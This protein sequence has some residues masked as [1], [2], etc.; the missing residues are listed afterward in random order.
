MEESTHVLNN[1]LHVTLI[2]N[3]SDP[4][5]KVG[6]WVRSG[7][8]MDS[9]KW[10]GSLTA[11][12]IMRGTKMHSR[13]KFE[14][15]LEEHSLLYGI[16]PSGVSSFFTEWVGGTPS[17]EHL[18]D[19][20]GL[21][22]E[23]LQFPSF[24][25]DE[26]EIVRAQKEAAIVKN[27]NDP[28]SNAKSE[29]R[30]MLYG[31]T[32]PLFALSVAENT[33]NLKAVTRDNLESFWKKHY[34][35]GHSGIVVVGDIDPLSVCECIDEVFGGWVQ[36][37]SH[38]EPNWD[39][40]DFGSDEYEERVISLPGNASA[41]LLI[42]QRMP[43]S[44]THSDYPAL[45]IAIN[46]LGGGMHSRLFQHVREKHGLSYH[47]GA[48]LNGMHTMPGY[49]SAI[50]MTNPDNI[51]KTQ[52][53]T[54]RVITEFCDKGITEE[55]LAQEK[56]VWRGARAFL[57]SSFSGIANRVVTDMITGVLRLDLEGY[58]ARLTLDEVNSAIHKYINPTRMKVVRAGSV[59]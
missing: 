12:M 50:A 30:R 17:H 36:Q 28:D 14:D 29:I 8:L 9:Q 31:P 58:I 43:I 3:H 35:P 51:S 53:E 45:R 20:I 7:P 26:L 22:Y 2:P 49:F 54:W 15:M 39:M 19:L 48:S 10:V 5:V 32:H 4:I 18:K 27:S 57:G 25:K 24:P 13:E 16:G 56:A 33:A 37:G 44:S 40:S 41:T 59:S 11:Y 46:A 34:A 1:G 52:E 47:A 23:S 55:E 42:G 6:G 38:A 21:V